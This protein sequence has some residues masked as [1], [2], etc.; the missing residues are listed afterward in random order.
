MAKSVI[1]PVTQKI[2]E[3]YGTLVC[4]CNKHNLTVGT[5]KQIIGGHQKSQ[6]VANIL[7][8]Q[9]YIQ[10]ADDLMKKHDEKKVP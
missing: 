10:S 5:F 4:F 7:I 2:R 3:D 1:S 6:R 8:E 9:G